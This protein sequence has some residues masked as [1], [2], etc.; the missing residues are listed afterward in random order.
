DNLPK[1]HLDT[2]A[3][4]IEENTKGVKP[5]TTILPCLQ[6][7]TFAI[8]NYEKVE[9]LLRNVC[10]TDEQLITLAT[11]TQFIKA[12]KGFHLTPEMKEMIQLLV[13]HCE[14]DQTKLPPVLDLF[15]GLCLKCMDAVKYFETVS[16]YS[17]LQHTVF[18]MIKNNTATGPIKV[19]FIKFLANC[20][21][22][23]PPEIF[24]HVVHST[25]PDLYAFFRTEMTAAIQSN[26]LNVQGAISGVLLNLSI[27]AINSSIA[28]MLADGLFDFL[29]ELFM[30]T[31]DD[32]TR[33]VLLLGIGNFMKQDFLVRRD[34]IKN[35]KLMD[36]I[37]NNKNK[38][39]QAINDE[40]NELVLGVSN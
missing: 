36:I 29:I 15:G 25:Y 5:Q 8:K 11:M 35:T 7:K 1:E 3:K 19:M 39:I 34:F 4:F 21:V 2:V 9:E 26:N 30:I 33:A 17:T 40:I 13:Q 37:K 18:E 20:F 22:T 6:R 12:G 38:T 24:M 10:T 28:G 23:T 14:I 16:V 31:T 32:N 27:S